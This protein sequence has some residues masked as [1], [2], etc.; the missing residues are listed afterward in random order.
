MFKDILWDEFIKVE[1][2]G[3]YFRFVKLEPR[4]GPLAGPTIVL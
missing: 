3:K 1:L 2:K 4:R